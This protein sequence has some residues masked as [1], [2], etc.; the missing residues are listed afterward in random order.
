M[1]GSAHPG[2]TRVVVIIPGRVLVNKQEFLY[3]LEFVSIVAI[4]LSSWYYS[5]SS[6]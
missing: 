2:T 1:V 6:L 4:K 5:V 3:L